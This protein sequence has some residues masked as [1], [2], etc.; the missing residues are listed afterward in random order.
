M[1]EEKIEIHARD[2]SP[3]AELR[4]KHQIE[5]EDKKY[6]N[7][8]SSCCFKIDRRATRYFTQLGIAI[9]IIS[10][11]IVQLIRNDTCE[12]QQLYSGILMTV[13]GVMLPS[14]SLH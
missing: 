11:C 2:R 13:I 1:N 8:W 4:E 7:E 12:S 5:L 3:V 6:E 9:M 10:F 14:P